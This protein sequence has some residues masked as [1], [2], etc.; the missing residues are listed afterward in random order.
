MMMRSLL[1]LVL[2]VSTTAFTVPSARW[3]VTSSTSSLQN[4]FAPDPD[5]KPLEVASEGE[6][7]AVEASIAS[8]DSSAVASPTM[9]IKNLARGGEVKEGTLIIR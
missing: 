7:L 4:M 3:G 5:A 1:L 9:T 2:A 6:S 8:I